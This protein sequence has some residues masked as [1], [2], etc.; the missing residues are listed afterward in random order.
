MRVAVNDE[1]PVDH[2]RN[3]EDVVSGD[4]G[5][6]NVHVCLSRVPVI[7]WTKLAPLTVV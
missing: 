2:Q 1:A 6:A 3:I 4:A 5:Y 7:E